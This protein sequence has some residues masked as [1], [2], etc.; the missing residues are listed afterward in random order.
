MNQTYFFR[1]SPRKLG[2]PFLFS[3]LTR[4]LIIFFIIKFRLIIPIAK[5]TQIS[6][7]SVFSTSFVTDSA[8]DQVDVGKDRESS[9]Y[10]DNFQ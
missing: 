10:A 5:K 3:S 2:I 8:D 4:T 7:Y 9:N 6:D 1:L